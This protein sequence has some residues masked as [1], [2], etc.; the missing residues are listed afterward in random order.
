M[1]DCTS[2]ILGFPACR[3]PARRLALRTGMDYADVGIHTFPDG[4]SLVRLPSDLPQHV[5]LY[6]SL[7][8]ANRRL[9]DLELAAAMAPGLGAQRLTLIAP[10]LCYMR[11]DTAFHRG[12]AVSQRV[13]GSAGTPLRRIDHGRSAPAPHPRP[14]RRGS[15]APG[16]CAQRSAADGSV[17]G[18]P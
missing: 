17:A 18:V 2:I 11:Q 7:D 16:G 3:Q 12:E 4:E 6:C 15:H 13:I 14:A 8:D 1:P 5:I 10:Y 9:T